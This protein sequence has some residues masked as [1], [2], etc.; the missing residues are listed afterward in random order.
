[1]LQ[2]AVYWQLSPSNPARRVK[3]PKTKKPKM[4][5]LIKILKQKVLIELFQYRIISQKLFLN[6]KNGMMNK[7]TS[8]ETNGLNLI[9]YLY[10]IMGNLCIQIPLENGLN[11]I[12]KN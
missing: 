1:M 10:K 8:V 11:L 2:N 7:K 6:I 3:P 4:E 12:L 9:N 5:F